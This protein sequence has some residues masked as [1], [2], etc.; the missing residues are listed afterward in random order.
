MH[1]HP[2]ELINGSELRAGMF[3]ELELGWM[4]HPFPTNSFKITSERQIE[5]IRNLGLT[6]VRYLPSKSDLD[7]GQISVAP[8][9]LTQGARRAPSPWALGDDEASPQRLQ[10]SN[11]L[12]V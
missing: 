9:L 12:D 3:V 6:Q 1:E 11:L 5:V 4:A 2:S 10:R 8:E 7:N